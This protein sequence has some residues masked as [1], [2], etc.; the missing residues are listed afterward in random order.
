M[1]KKPY[2]PALLAALLS[3][4]TVITGPETS[5]AATPETRDQTA[6]IL[7]YHRFGN[8][9]L[10]ATNIT[11][12]QLDAHIA[13]IKASARPVLSLKDYVEGRRKGRVTGPAII[14]TVDDAYESFA[15]N[16]WPKFKAASL[17]VTLFVATEA[18]DN[19]AAT[20]MSWDSL[21]AL[22]ADGV[23]IGHHS[24]KH[25]HLN[26]MSLAAV[27]S[28][29]EVAS[30]R[31]EAELGF[32]P[33]L[34]SYPFGEFNAALEA[35]VQDMG[36]DAAVAQYS[37]AAGSHDDLYAL[38]RFALN[39]HY[40][41]A[42]RFKTIMRVRTVVLA[43]R[44]EPRDPLLL[45]PNSPIIGR[46]ELTPTAPPVSA[47]TCFASFLST[48][49]EAEKVDRSYTVRVPAKPPKGRSRINCTAS[50]DFGLAWIGMP[51]FVPTGLPP[52]Q[53]F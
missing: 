23:D 32:V 53:G 6:L 15:Q 2:S 18:L 21:R 24:H 4:L 1:F 16:G 12:D 34:F 14:I 48:P 33:T 49:I 44:P 47:F 39:E 25:W 8:S 51:I 37:G 40:G 31:F 7:T 46:F 42:D 10:P 20:V 27:Q 38:P 17:P 50:G 11:L 45:E 5:H 35:V 19:R 41:S 36:F 26:A 52:H 3:M 30:A 9:D 28:D 22:V 43:G 13:A 29:I